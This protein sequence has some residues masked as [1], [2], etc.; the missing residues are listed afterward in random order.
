MYQVDFAA[1]PR[2]P[3]MELGQAFYNR[4]LGVS[5]FVVVSTLL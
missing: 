3:Y 4:I 2:T 5:V 1:N